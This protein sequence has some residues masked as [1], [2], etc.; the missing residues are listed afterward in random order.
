MTISRS[1]QL[2]QTPDEGNE[3]LI[4]TVSILSSS[5]QSHHGE[6][7]SS[8]KEK[9]TNGHLKYI[10]FLFFRAFCYRFKS[11]KVQ[12]GRPHSAAWPL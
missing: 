12:S 7:K 5:L 11:F 9:F 10:C 4:I 2:K 8:A 3:K 1:N 6:I